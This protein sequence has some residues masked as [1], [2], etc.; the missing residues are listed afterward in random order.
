ML[1]SRWPD[2]CGTTSCV[3]AR[4]SGAYTEI[5]NSNDPDG[6][7]IWLPVGEWH[8]LLDTIRA[9]GTPPGVEADAAGD[10]VVVRVTE[11]PFTRAEWSDFEAKVRAGDYDTEPASEATGVA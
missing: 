2:P 5:R 8:Y 9:G 10:V 1:T 3:D 11:I 4:I 6:P 7:R